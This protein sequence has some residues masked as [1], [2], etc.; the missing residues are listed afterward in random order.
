MDELQKKKDTLKGKQKLLAQWALGVTDFNEAN[1]EELTKRNNEV[2]GIKGE[3]VNMENAYSIIKATQTDLDEYEKLE[4][5]FFP[6]GNGNR[7]DGRGGERVRKGDEGLSTKSLGE[8]LIESEAFTKYNKHFKSGPNAVFEVKT[9]F[10]ETTGNAGMVG[11]APQIIRNGV[12]VEI[13]QRKPKMN[14]VIPQSRVNLNAIMYQAETVN[15]DGSTFVHEDDATTGESAFV[16]TDVTEPVK[17]VRVSLPISDDMLEDAPYMMDFVNGRL[18]TQLAR[19]VDQALINGDGSGDN[20]TGLL[21]RSGIQTNTVTALAGAGN[22]VDAL[23]K[24]MT[25]VLLVSEYDP[26]AIVLHPLNWETVLLT[27]GSGGAYLYGDPY[28]ARP[29]RIWGVD[30]ID[31]KGM[32]VNTALIGAF[33][34]ACTQATR[35]DVTMSISTEHAD[36]WMK[37]RVVVKLEMRFALVVYRPPALYALTGLS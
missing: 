35:R 10:Q 25:Q 31:T 20:L 30:V 1:S 29:N 14:M 24:A 9:V 3:I 21:S 32:P 36:N 16:L 5:G 11:Y 7:D 4:K 6:G 19:K 33:D 37:G 26:N 17:K 28:N 15:T 23:H 12:V 34:A 8:M 27:K 18:M 22:N 2:N 13:A